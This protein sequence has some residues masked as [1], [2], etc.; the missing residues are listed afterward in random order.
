MAAPSHVSTIP[1]SGY[2]NGGAVGTLASLAR[3]ASLLGEDEEL[4]HDIALGMEPEDGCLTV[5]NADDEA[6]VAFT[7][8]G[9]ENLK[10]RLDDLKR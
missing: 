5:L 2:S 6:T 3:V 9:I 7:P 4:L 10:E 1:S 8:Q